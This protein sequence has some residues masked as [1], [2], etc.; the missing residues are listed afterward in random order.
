M[1][2]GETDGSQG[3]EMAEGCRKGK[4]DRGRVKEGRDEG[5]KEVRKEN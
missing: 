3:R 5:R 1:K 2:G 4:T